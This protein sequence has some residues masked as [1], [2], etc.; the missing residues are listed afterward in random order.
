M[1]MGTAATA[2]EP[3]RLWVKIALN[4]ALLTIAVSVLD[5]GVLYLVMSRVIGGAMV[6]LAA[7]SAEILADQLATVPVS[8][9]DDVVA[10]LRRNNEIV[11]VSPTGEVLAGRLGDPLSVDVGVVVMTRDVLVH[12]G[13]HRLEAAAPIGVRT[14]AVLV[15]RVPNAQ[16]ES[17]AWTV[18]IAHAS[19]SAALLALMGWIWFRGSLVQPLGRIRAAIRR[20]AGGE[21]GI[22]VH[23]DSAQEIAEL[24]ASLNAVSLALAQ[25]RTQTSEQLQ[26]LAQANNDLRATQDALVRSEK[27][28][29][30]GRLAAGIAHEV[31]N[32]LTVVR[33]YL[34]FLQSGRAT[35]EMN[36]DLLGRCRTE[37]ERMHRILRTLL[38]YARA[39]QRQ[40]GPVR[41]Q[42]LLQ[43]AGRTVQHLAPFAAV[44]LEISAPPTLLV[45]GEQERL[46]QI[47]VNLLL[48]AANAGARRITLSAEATGGRVRLRC[49]D[50]GGGIEPQHLSRIFEPFFTTQ[51]PGQGTGLGLAIVHQVVE[52]HGGHIDVQ[53]TVGQGT[54]FTLDLPGTP[55]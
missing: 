37:V 55:P 50:D 22:Q 25:Y 52:Q 14:D 8:D 23:E 51:P 32:P 40:S 30:V 7:T 27:L 31:G 20:I 15:L 6:E 33:G 18:V 26:D 13:S 41:V 53:S 9:L 36:R 17:P 38:D 11:V 35:P 12:E 47:L 48:N 29:S 34:E 3:P 44:H 42:A 54:V 28:A 39:E 10:A 45:V 19:L 24:S 43:D 4:L 49:A 21:F 46:H 2:P 1:K 5:V 16:I